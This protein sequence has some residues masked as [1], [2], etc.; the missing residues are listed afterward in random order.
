MKNK[1]KQE[2]LSEEDKQDQLLDDIRR[3][4]IFGFVK[5][6]IHVPDLFIDKFSEYF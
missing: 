1:D 2:E 3:D 6:D 4:K 5:C